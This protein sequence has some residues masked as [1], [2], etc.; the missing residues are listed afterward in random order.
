VDS[1]SRPQPVIPQA[2]TKPVNASSHSANKARHVKRKPVHYVVIARPPKVVSVGIEVM[3]VAR[4][5]TK[6]HGRL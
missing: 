5:K 2:R 3:T 4:E 1:H 6:A